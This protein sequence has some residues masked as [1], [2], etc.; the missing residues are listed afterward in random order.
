MI[1]VESWDSLGH[2]SIVLFSWLSF[3][4]STT[5]I[6]YFHH[7]TVPQKWFFI[8]KILPS[9]ADTSILSLERCAWKRGHCWFSPALLFLYVSVIFTSNAVALSEWHSQFIRI[10]INNSLDVMIRVMNQ[11]FFEDDLGCFWARQLEI[12]LMISTSVPTLTGCCGIRFLAMMMVM[13][14]MMIGD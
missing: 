11:F 5:L 9:A 1:T 14:M 3:C 10:L 4:A 12:T 8:P 13:I 7:W 2:K 6:L